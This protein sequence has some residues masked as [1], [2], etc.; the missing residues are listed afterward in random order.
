VIA[1]DRVPVG[2]EANALTRL[3]S[4]RR[5]V[6][7]PV[8]DLTESNPTRV[9]LPYPPGLLAPLADARGLRYAPEPLGL[10]AAR[11]A[12]AR[13][14][15]RR[16]AVVRPESIVL[17]ASTSEMYSWLFK[18]LCGA[19]DSILVP[20]PS[21]PLFEHLTRLEHVQAVPYRLEYHG[22]WSVDVA[23]LAQAPARTR[24][25]LV[26]SPN[27][28]T[29][30]FVTAGD[31]EG[32]RAICRT[33]GWALIV[34]EVFADYA[35]EAT[36]PL[37][38]IAAGASD[39]LTFTLGGLSKAVGLPQLKLGWAVV[40][41]PPGD[42]RQALD[43]LEL[44]ADTFLSVGTPV[45]LAADELLRH[46]AVVRVAIQGRVRA[47]LDHLRA[48]VAPVPSC[49]VLPVDGGWSAVLRV[50]ATRSE[51]ALVL[52]LLAREGVLV[53][54]GYFFDFDH[55]A[56]LVLSLLPPPDVF[57]DACARVLRFVSA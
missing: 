22:R 57:V 41:G 35:V 8:I 20:Q 30:S 50:P 44:I 55:E 3:L 48:A 54:P 6:G 10:A 39:V 46:G 45:Q 12:V 2:V 47:N 40:G 38:D 4:E 19:G 17:A 14:A 13:D 1:S 53:H 18:L 37:T 28:P 5:A 23:S 16:G 29:G 7:A 34:D 32:V 52:E 33:R 56:F 27:N 9:G 24:A 25:V 21:Y 49:E 11:E 42:V 51:E 26:V 36:S 31:L 43:G 15:L